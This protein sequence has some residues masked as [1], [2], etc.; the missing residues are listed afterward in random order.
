MRKWANKMKGVVL[1]SILLPLLLLAYNDSD[2]DGISDENDLCPNSTMTDIVD[3]K[4]CTI[5]K[6]VM[7]KDNPHHFD[8]IMGVNYTEDNKALNESLQVDY[9]Y[10]DFA[11]QLQTANYEE[12]G[13][14]DTFV[15]LYYNFKPS[16]KLSFRLGGS[17]ILPTYDSVLDNNNVDYKASLALSYQ[18][19][20]FSLFGG[21]SL[22]LVN[23]D[24]VNSSMYK[25]DYQNSHNYYMGVGSYFFSKL[26]SSLLYSSSSSIYKGSESIN[27]LSL[28]NYYKIDGDWFSS[29]GYNR[30]LNSSSSDQVYINFGYYF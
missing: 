24:D 17:V 18:I 8:I 25:V 1:L 7:P 22:T 5:E 21:V 16:S 2:F 13:V 19:D 30:G 9:Y 10:K 29:F 27:S 20:S 4:G 12:G 14:G 26:Y 6:L 15:S 28:Y 23:D 3:M 11:L